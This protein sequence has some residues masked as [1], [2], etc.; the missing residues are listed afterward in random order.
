MAAIRLKVLNILTSC[1]S[2]LE[3]WQGKTLIFTFL[4]GTDTNILTGMQK[5]S[6]SSYC[7]ENLQLKRINTAH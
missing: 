5:Q 7:L 2:D 1:S 6:K 4:I 3:C